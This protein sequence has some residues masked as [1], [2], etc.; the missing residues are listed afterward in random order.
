MLGV[1]LVAGAAAVSE[2][3]LETMAIA[4]GIDLPKVFRIAASREA[5]VT[6][7]E[8]SVSGTCPGVF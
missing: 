7:T 2:Q 4:F 3:V 5:I 6:C 1:S 8:P